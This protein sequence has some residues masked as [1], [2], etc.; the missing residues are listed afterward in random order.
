MFV[1]AVLVWREVFARDG[2]T[3]KFY[4]LDV[5]QGDALFIETPSGNQILID[6]GPDKAVLRELGEVMPFY[7]R[8]IDLV[9]LT[10]PHLDHVGG[11]VEV[12]K[13]YRIN[14][15]IG[16]GDAHTIAEFQELERLVK[17]KNIGY[18]QARRGM[19]IVLDD[20]TELLILPP[21][22]LKS[23]SNL[24]N[25]MIT[26]RLT[27]GAMDFLLMGDAERPL[28]FFLFEKGDEIQSE[29]LKVGHHGSKTSSS[30]LFLEQ[31]RPQFALISVGRKN[32]YGH[33]HRE[34]L[35]SL[36]KIGAKILRTDLN[37]RIEISSDGRSL[38]VRPLR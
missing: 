3:L 10:H 18:V 4:V 13:N 19:K 15:Y 7:D 11:L 38:S 17:I 23:G 32:R 28:E 30:Q 12:F 33:P 8:T 16:S 25:N 21:A 27:Y 37:S 14:K 20:G 24:H 29:V 34:V 2:G 22:E 36:E 9:I 31:V 6:G 5:G 1:V 35:E 26:S